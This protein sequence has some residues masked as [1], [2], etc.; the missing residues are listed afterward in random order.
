MISVKAKAK[1]DSA[2]RAGESFE[3]KPELAQNATALNISPQ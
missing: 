1:F 2:K 3:D